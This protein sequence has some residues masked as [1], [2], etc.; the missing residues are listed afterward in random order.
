MKKIIENKYKIIFGLI[1]L[2]AAVLRIWQLTQTPSSLNWDEVSWGYNAYSMAETGKDEYNE[3]FPIT[4]RS[5]ND[6]K[7]AL[8]VYVLT[9]VVKIFGL[10]DFIVRLPI[11]L[12]GVLSVAVTYFLVLELFKRKDLA[13]L[14]SFLLAVSPWS[15]QF[16]RF[17]HEGILGLTLNL[18]MAL[19]FVKGLKNPKLLPLAA[20]FGGLSLYSYQNQKVFVPLFALILV[21]SFFNEFRKIPV[22]YILTSLL[23][24][25]CVSLPLL[26]HTINNP[27]TL[28]RAKGTSFINHPLG[29]LNEQFYPERNL[30]N[31]NNDDYLGR[32][33]DN[34]RVVYVKDVVE[35]YILHFDPNFLFLNGEKNIRH[36]PQYVG[37]LYLI[38]L[39]FLLIGLYFL[40][41]GKFKK[42]VKSFILLWMLIAPIPAMVTWDVPHSGRTLN[43]LPTF[44]IL[45]A[46]GILSFVTFTNSLKIKKIFKYGIF[47]IIASLAVFN[48][49]FYL[50]QYFVQ[51]K[52]YSSQDW[53]YGYKDIINEVNKRE[54]RFDKIIVSSQ[55]PLDQSYIFFL[56]H[57]K[58]DPAKYQKA[59]TGEYKPDN[60][61]KK[62]DFRRIDWKNEKGNNLYIGSADDFKDGKEPRVLKEIKYLNGET[63]ILIV[64]G[65]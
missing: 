22:K 44:Q 1:I 29:V 50:N 38:E 4:L 33:L 11:A 32:V 64:D 24:G 30:Q 17:A 59:A 54:S 15:I 62:Y 58:Y 63:G 26:F 52:Y 18:L 3:S 45:I 55:K 43:F 31:I 9:P 49:I 35:N 20:I 61:F 36:A 5:L 48:F 27:E 42:S 40:I 13:L 25:L 12:L 8:Y 65:N 46:L 2:I 57:T 10:S 51:Y 14:S 6:Y 37:H 41:F 7:P 47:T 16:S 23:V 19:F 53:Q 56:Y 60:A 39:P 21:I 34:R 28:S